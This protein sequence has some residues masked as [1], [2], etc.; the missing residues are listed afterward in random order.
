MIFL[1]VHLLLLQPTF[2]AQS[3]K[4]KAQSSKLKAQSS[5]LKAQSSKLKRIYNQL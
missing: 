2:R 4:L 5:K 3:S 1:A